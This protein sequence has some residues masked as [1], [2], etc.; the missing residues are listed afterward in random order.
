[1]ENQTI[2][3]RVENVPE[4]HSINSEITASSAL[5]KLEERLPKFESEIKDPAGLV[6]IILFCTA[7]V[8]V[9]CCLWLCYQYRKRTTERS[10]NPEER[11]QTLKIEKSVRFSDQLETI[12]DNN[13]SDDFD[14]QNLTE[15]E[16]DTLDN[17]MVSEVTS[18]TKFS[19][20]PKNDNDIDNETNNKT[21]GLRNRFFGMS[22]EDT[23]NT[24]STTDFLKKTFRIDTNRKKIN[25]DKSGLTDLIEA[26][27]I[28]D[29]AFTK[30]FFKRASK[31]N[32][33]KNLDYR[34]EVSDVI[35]I[36]NK[37]LI[38]MI[39]KSKNL[40]HGLDEETINKILKKAITIRNANLRKC[41]RLRNE[42]LL[43][44]R[45]KLSEI[46]GKSEIQSSWYTE[47]NETQSDNEKSIKRLD[48][49]FFKAKDAA[50]DYLVEYILNSIIQLNSEI[51]YTTL[52]YHSKKTLNGTLRLKTIFSDWK[53]EFTLDSSDESSE[54]SSEGYSEEY[55]SEE[56]DKLNESSHPPTTNVLNLSQQLI[57]QSTTD[58]LKNTTT[59][60][61]KNTTTDDLKNT[62]TDDLKNT[63]TD[64]LKNTTTDDLTEESAN[65]TL[66]TFHEMCVIIQSQEDIN[67]VGENLNPCDMTNTDI[68]TESLTEIEDDPEQDLSEITPTNT[69]TTELKKINFEELSQRILKIGY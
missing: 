16:T 17:E 11:K 22:T 44:Q 29:D 53:K 63:T 24:I 61:L 57:P 23:N 58:D 49:L 12:V 45:V 6:T 37:T 55:S 14:K 25:T 7:I 2:N 62:T 46:N 19:N 65:K 30:A 9:S 26:T 28:G 59:D 50:N 13:T 56:E 18:K 31:V 5:I 68:K 32:S 42:T 67:E 8:V 52:N 27:S 47:N 38:H 1:M 15:E 66:G 21:F 64:D 10:V 20:N 33:F 48:K 40:N 60:D 3:D 51:E 4:T 35:E 39:R 54:E 41:I 43:N 69:P 34:Q 36:G